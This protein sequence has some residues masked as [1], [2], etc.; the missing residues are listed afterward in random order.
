M[1]SRI[2]NMVGNQSAT[3]VKAAIQK[4]YVNYKVKQKQVNFINRLMQ[5]KGGKIISAVRTWKDLPEKNK[6][7]KVRN[8]HKFYSILKKMADKVMIST[9]KPFVDIYEDG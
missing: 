2:S 7:S 8:G 5:T 6:F 1:V 4:L 9:F 3:G